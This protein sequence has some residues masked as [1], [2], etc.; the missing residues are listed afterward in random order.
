LRK[1]ASCCS[2]IIFLCLTLLLQG[3][4]PFTRS[5]NDQEDKVSPAILT[6]AYQED[7]LLHLPLYAAIKQDFFTQKNITVELQKINNS[8]EAVEGLLSGQYDLV[9]SGPEISFYSY[10][11]GEPEKLV[12]IAQSACKNGHFLL[13][14]KSEN[15]F[16]WN[17]VKGKVVI[18]THSGEASQIALENILRKEQL[19]PFLDVHMVNNLPP[20]LR[21]GIFRSGTGQ[22][23][24]SDEPTATILE[25]ENLG[26][27]VTSLDEHLQI[28]I[29]T[30]F[31]ATKSNFKEKS[32][33][34]QNFVTALQL[35]L[36]WIEEKSPEEIATV[37]QSF[38]PEQKEKILLRGICRYKNMGCW[39]ENPLLTE[40]E[41]QQFQQ[42]LL[43]A[44][45]LNSPLPL[46]ELIKNP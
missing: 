24:L 5:E 7:S 30:V 42:I 44:Q 41:L 37:A 18:G 25:N 12:F 3:C 21:A 39:S 13:S 23:I 4:S 43:D 11:R 36:T 29:P 32:E 20:T 46:Y 16:T 38:F 19:R 34:Y 17:E 2:M 31:M 26:Q 22:F 14:R 35:G 8:Q 45:E 28:N 1:S 27:V 33:L 6:I 10:Q 15:P 9:L 40:K